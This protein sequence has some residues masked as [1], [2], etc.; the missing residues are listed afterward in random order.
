MPH[1]V[2][3]LRSLKDGKYYIGETTN[4]EARLQF[5]NAG[6]QRSTRNRR[7]FVIVLVE[8]HPDRLVALKRE[9]EIKSWKGGI[10]F[11]QLLEIG[12]Q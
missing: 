12:G 11:K 7:P 1:Y 8:T 10:K 4:V 2:Y 5:H 3:I 9:K 6:L